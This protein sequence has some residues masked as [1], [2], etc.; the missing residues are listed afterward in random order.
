MTRPWQNAKKS[1][2]HIKDASIFRK[3]N[4]SSVS[5]N[6]VLLIAYFKINLFDGQ[7]SLVNFVY[8]IKCWFLKSHDLD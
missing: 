5:I 2:E 3:K 8:I 7:L 1:D 4:L 6:I